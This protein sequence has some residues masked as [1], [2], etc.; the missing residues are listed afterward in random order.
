M[1]EGKK[2]YYKEKFMEDILNDESKFRD[3][4]FLNI[5]LDLSKPIL[6]G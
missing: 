2:Q 4:D 3:W 6:H 1:V 5:G